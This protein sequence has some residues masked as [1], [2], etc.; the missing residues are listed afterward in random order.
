MKTPEVLARQLARQ[1]ENADTR[2]ARLLDPGAWP[3][4]L[5]VGKP[6]PSV[7]ERDPARV[8]EHLKQWREV[9][10]GIVHWKP[11]PYQIGRAHV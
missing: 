6:P 1:W 7:V 4:R 5:P 3:V 8:R 9:R 2:E 11:I 10:V